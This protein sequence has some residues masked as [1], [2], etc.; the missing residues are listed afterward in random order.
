ML[1]PSRSTWFQLLSLTIGVALLSSCGTSGPP[2]PPL[3]TEI[4]SVTFTPPSPATLKFGEDVIAELTYSSGHSTPIRMWANIEYD[5]PITEGTL[6]Y[7]PSPPITAKQGTV[8]R[9]FS[10]KAAYVNG[11]PAPI[12][13]D[14]IE[15]SIADQHQTVELFEEYVT[16]DYTWVP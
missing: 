5:G 12:H 14:T 9:C 2:T 13:V 1:Q 7:C 6:T 8:G 16:V 15:L 11:E 3:L 4:V 10:V